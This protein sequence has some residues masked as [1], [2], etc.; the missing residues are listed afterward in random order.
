MQKRKN[1]KLRL[2]RRVKMLLELIIEMAILSILSFNF[3]KN[4]DGV[5]ILFYVVATRFMIV[6]NDYIK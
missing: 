3:S 5:V 2:K 1:K 4:V 6:L